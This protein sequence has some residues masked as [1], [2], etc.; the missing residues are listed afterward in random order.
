MEE[1]DE[2]K[3]EKELCAW[4]EWKVVCSIHGCSEPNASI[5]KE[6]VFNAFFRKINFVSLGKVQI[7]IDKKNDFANDFDCGIIEKALSPTSPLNY[8]DHVWRKMK[9]SPDEPLK[10]IRGD[11]VGKKGII[12]EIAE[13]YMRENYP[14]R[15]CEK[16]IDGK[17]KKFYTIFPS[18][19]EK[20]NGAEN[21]LTWEERIQSIPLWTTPEFSSEEE[22]NEFRTFIKE[23]F[24]DVQSIIL[25][26]KLSDI[27]LDNKFVLQYTDLRKSRIYEIWE[28][29]QAMSKRMMGD[30]PELRTA[31]G[32]KVFMEVL[33]DKIS[34]EKSRKPLL[35]MIERKFP[36][37]RS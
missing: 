24:N 33:F 18:M 9:D 20:A 5:L 3:D 15:K 1:F 26:A 28:D 14:W 17:R 32:V 30:F 10:V 7:N 19:Q 25:L 2:Q 6:R 4:N 23:K 16:V 31:E 12:N 13:K 8:K 34:T 22:I 36:F 11:L 37:L 29:V 35:S 21:G 27:S